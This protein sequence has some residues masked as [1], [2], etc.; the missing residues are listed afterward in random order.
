MGMI[1]SRHN[2]FSAIFDRHMPDITPHNAGKPGSFT[3][4][5]IA[6]KATAAAGL[7]K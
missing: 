1:R 3:L 4:F 6:R 5:G 2:I 7:I